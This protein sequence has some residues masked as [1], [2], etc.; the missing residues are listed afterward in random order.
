VTIAYPY[1]ESPFHIGHARTYTM[2]DIRARYMRMK[3]KTTLLS[4]GFHYTGTPILAMARRIQKGDEE[5]IRLYR[6]LFQIPQEVVA[7]FNDP[8]YIANYFREDMRRACE[9]MGYSMDWRRTFTTIDPCYSKMIEWQFRRLRALGLIKQGTYPVGWCPVDRNPMGMHDTRGDVDPEIGEFVTI[10]FRDEQGAIFATATLRPETVYGVTNLWINPRA[11]YVKARVGAEV[12]VMARPAAER[13]SHQLDIAIEDEVPLASLLGRRVRNPI[14]NAWV[15]VLPAEF[16]LPDHGTGVVMSVPA[17]SPDDYLA[18]LEAKAKRADGAGAE[19][20]PIGV[21]RLEGYGEAPARDAVERA[22][23]RSSLDPR[24]KQVTAELYSEEYNR[25]VMN[26]RTP[27]AG[28]PVREARERVKRELAKAGASATVYELMN[29]PVFCRCGAEI[30]VKLLKDQ[31]FID[32]ANPA[33]KEKAREALNSMQILPEGYRAYYEHT[34]GWLREKPCARSSGLGTPLP[35]DR[36][37]IVESLSD[38]TIYM[39]YYIIARYV[40]SGQLKP[41]HL[42]EAFFDFVF[43]GRGEAREVARAT[44]LPAELLL[45]IRQEFEYFYPVDSRHSAHELIPN[46]LTFFIFNHVALFE[47]KHW[48]RAIVT[49]GHV[50]MKG[51]KMSKSLGNIIP[52]RQAIR[53]YGADPIRIAVTASA[54]LAS[55]ADISLERVREYASKLEALYAFAKA[56]TAQPLPSPREVTLDLEER[57]LLSMVQ[58]RA[59]AATEAIEKMDVKG[60]VLQALFLM[61]QDIQWYLEFCKARGKGSDDARVRA[62]LGQLLDARVRLLAPVTPHLCEEIW[63]LMG[64]EGYVSVAPW[65]EPEVELIDE[66]ALEA[67]GM[68]QALV[69]D[70]QALSRRRSIKGKRLTLYVAAQWKRELYSRVLRGLTMG[71]RPDEVIRAALE[72]MGGELKGAPEVAKKMAEL[73]LRDPPDVR[74]RR[75]R[76]QDFDEKAWLKYAAPF[77]KQRAGAAEVLVYCEEEAEGRDPL[78]R[79]KLSLPFRPGIY[80]E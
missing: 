32:Y 5:A 50:L 62:A 13:L 63:A 47:R 34:I 38:S 58:A 16:V 65:P 45:Q 35:W 24:L 20:R 73:I 23:I 41:E 15:P 60:L 57:W 64:K 75:L 1:P 27:L 7:K 11:T 76:L 31:W 56:L 22:G 25:G 33:W 77:I 6:E 28:L 2:G 37:W 12:W 21:I 44:G 8:L 29:K 26:E 46:H 14:T 9:E 53:R 70:L 19:L 79:S 17:H 68:L 10:K 3:G 67:M 78:G 71:G 49:N 42:S 43:L 18:L 36:N 61:E 40:N 74:Q 39:A 51:Q 80:S 69:Q 66:G 52:L 30:V 4:L 48:P 54:D 55:D 59:R 72:G